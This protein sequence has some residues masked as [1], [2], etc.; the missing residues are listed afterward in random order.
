MKD[1]PKGVWLGSFFE[2]DVLLTQEKRSVCCDD[3]S[4]Q[5]FRYCPYCSKLLSQSPRWVIP[6]FYQGKVL[7]SFGRTELEIENISTKEM[8]VS[9]APERTDDLIRVIYPPKFDVRSF[10][11]SEKQWFIGQKTGSCER[12]STIG[13]ASFVGTFV[14]YLE[15]AD[16]DKIRFQSKMREYL[17]GVVHKDHPLDVMSVL[18]PVLVVSR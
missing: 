4:L 14:I 7:G 1:F 12:V 5:D 8:L 16:L 6:E 2:K 3:F 13:P 11:T 18:K 15:S 10:S 17:K 9:I